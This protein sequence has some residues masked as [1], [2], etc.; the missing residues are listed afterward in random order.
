[1]ELQKRMPLA[2][3]QLKEFGALFGSPVLST[4]DPKLFQGILD[5][6]MAAI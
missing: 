5:Q 2:E 4:E 3:A 1:M 6:V